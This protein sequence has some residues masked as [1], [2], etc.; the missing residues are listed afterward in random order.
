MRV[1]REYRADLFD[2]DQYVDSTVIDE[3]NPEFAMELFKDECGNH[4]L[5]PDA[6]V[7]IEAL[8]LY[9]ADS[10]DD[11]PETE[12]NVALIEE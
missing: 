2:N 5:S 3:N 1:K 9:D 4:K 7:T 12:E 8:G 6:F 10:G 11:L